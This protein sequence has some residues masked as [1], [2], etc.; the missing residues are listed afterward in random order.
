MRGEESLCGKREECKS[1]EEE[2]RWNVRKTEKRNEDETL[3]EHKKGE[4][5]KGKERK[6]RREE[7]RK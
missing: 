1:S 5:K 2:I 7:K 6:E 3:R 4:E